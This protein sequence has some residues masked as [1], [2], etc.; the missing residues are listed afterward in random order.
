MAAAKAAPAKKASFFERYKLGLKLKSPTGVQL[1][2]GE[3][4]ALVEIQEKDVEVLKQNEKDVIAAIGVTKNIA[5][6][7]QISKAQA[8]RSQAAATYK[9]CKDPIKKREWARRLIIADSTRKSLVDLKNRMEVATAYKNPTIST[10][11][12]RGIS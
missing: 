5:V 10:E 9:I 12:G 8:A 6:G 11:N 7:N 1:S 4:Q 3:T 2:Q